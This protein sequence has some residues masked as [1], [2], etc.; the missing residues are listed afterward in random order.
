MEITKE[1]LDKQL[2]NQYKLTKEYFAQEFKEQ[3]KASKD[4]FD[5]QFKTQFKAS[6]DYFDKEF[7]GLKSEM[8]E[9]KMNI[10][11]LQDGQRDMSADIKDIKETLDRVD[12]RDLEDSNAFA[13]TLLSMAKRRRSS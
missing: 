9:M 8:F 13:K 5:E 4:Y 11:S 3:F 2:K 10:V 6:K 7:Y 12:K 1:Y